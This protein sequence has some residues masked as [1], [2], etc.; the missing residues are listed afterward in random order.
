MEFKHAACLGGGVIGASWAALFLASGR[1]V[2]M[3]DPDPDVERKVRDYV[4]TACPTMTEPGLTRNGAPDAI[5]FHTDAASAVA[6]VGLAQENVP[7]GLPIKHAIFAEIEPALTP[8]AIVASSASGLRWAAM[9]PTMLVNLGAG[10]GGHRA[11][12]DRFS[13]TFNGWRDDLGELYLTDE[14]AHLLAEGVEAVA[15]GK[16]LT[17]LA[18]KRGELIVTRRNS[19][20]DLR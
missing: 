11:F 13:D 7:E 5:T 8:D 6:G 18:E 19:T 1:S 15:R 12:C 4:E 16:A 3:Y 2:A 10:E 9:G 17:E 14:A 20:S